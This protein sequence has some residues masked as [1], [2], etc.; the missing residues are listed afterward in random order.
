[1]VAFTPDNK[2]IISIGG[3]PLSGWNSHM[4]PAFCCA[5]NIIIPNNVK[6]KKNCISY[7]IKYKQNG[8]VREQLK[9]IRKHGGMKKSVETK[10]VCVTTDGTLLYAISTVTS[11]DG[12]DIYIRTN[13]THSKE[14]LDQRKGKEYLWYKLAGMYNDKSN[15]DLDT[16]S[17]DLETDYGYETNELSTFDEGLTGN[18][19]YLI[20][21]FIKHWYGKARS[22]KNIRGNHDPFKNFDFGFGWLCFFHLRLNKIGDTDLMNASYAELRK[23]VLSLSDTSTD[24]LD[25]SS[26]NPVP[27]TPTTT[28]RR[29]TVDTQKQQVTTLSVSKNNAASELIELQKQHLK[30]ELS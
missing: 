4:L 18:E 26:I 9:V 19:L 7:I 30:L 12:K 1:M 3:I 5:L 23:G 24:D 25:I 17:V 22:N 20:M 29:R 2:D 8:A 13:H 16:L 15:T 28:P 27:P 6:T 10:P 14:E 11:F 21:Q